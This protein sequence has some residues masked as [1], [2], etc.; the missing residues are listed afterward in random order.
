MC[1]E[2]KESFFF[3]VLELINSKLVNKGRIFVKLK[4]KEKVSR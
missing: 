4:D 3:V 1:D 2:V